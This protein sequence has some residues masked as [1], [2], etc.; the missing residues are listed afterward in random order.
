MLVTD[1]TKSKQQR[2]K[3]KVHQQS[4]LQPCYISKFYFSMITQQSQLSCASLRLLTHA[5]ICATT[6]TI[7]TEQSTHQPGSPP[8][9]SFIATPSP[10]SFSPDHWAVLR[11][12]GLWLF[13]EGHLNEAR[14]SVTFWGWI[15]SCHVILLRSIPGGSRINNLSFLSLSS[16]SF[17]GWATVCLSIHPL[18]D[19]CVASSVWQLWTQL[20]TG[21]CVRIKFHFSGINNRASLVAQ[22]VKNP[23]AMWVT[24]VQSLDW[25]DPPRREWLPTP[26]FWTGEFHGLYSPRGHK[27]SDTTEWLSFILAAT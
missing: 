20:C 17:Y 9:C 15:P 21:S 11:H 24:W 4:W 8:L 12:W 27:E 13:W 26:V 18:K 16:P 14:Q 1:V 2:R 6:T 10:H 19:I 22:Q 23:P 25:E 7:N 5:Y 3:L